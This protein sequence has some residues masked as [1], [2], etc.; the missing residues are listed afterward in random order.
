MADD[1]HNAETKPRKDLS[2]SDFFK[3]NRG[4]FLIAAGA[5]AVWALYKIDAPLWLG[6]GTLVLLIVSAAVWPWIERSKNRKWC[7][8]AV[9]LA[10]MIFGGLVI[11]RDK[12]RNVIITQDSNPVARRH[13]PGPDVGCAYLAFRPMYGAHPELGR[14]KGQAESA[15]TAYVAQHEKGYAVTFES[16]EQDHVFYLYYPTKERPE[17]KL[18]ILPDLHSANCDTWRN[19]VDNEARLGKAPSGR[20][21]PWAN[22]AKGWCIQPDRFKPIGWRLFHRGYSTNEIFVQNFDN[23]LI[24]G[25]VRRVA[26]DSFGSVLVLVTNRKI[27][28]AGTP[29]EAMTA[30]GYEPVTNCRAS[31]RIESCTTH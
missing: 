29:K 6:L 15:L 20:S 10:F 17:N 16:P 22:V 26:D 8:G 27:W 18:D 24:I 1:S 23:G 9:A 28:D 25:P 11:V 30:I 21:Q 2:L 14:C 13:I 31:S 3:P 5:I 7:F 12:R 19:D 4:W